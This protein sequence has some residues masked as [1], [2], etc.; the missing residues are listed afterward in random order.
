VF[1]A[2][3]LSFMASLSPRKSLREPRVRARGV[4]RIARHASGCSACTNFGSEWVV[5]GDCG[6][7]VFQSRTDMNDLGE[8]FRL[9]CDLSIRLRDMRHFVR[10]LRA[11]AIQ[12]SVFVVS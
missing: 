5:A 12:P 10:S 1:L 3:L 7:H 6:G 4:H 9:C 2:H 8:R 11:T